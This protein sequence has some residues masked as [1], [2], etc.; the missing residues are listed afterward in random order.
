MTLRTARRAGSAVSH[1]SSLSP[2]G[3]GHK[4]GG[5]TPNSPRG[6]PSAPPPTFAVQAVV[7]GEHNAAAHRVPFVAAGTEWVPHAAAV[8]DLPIICRSDSRRPP[9]DTGTPHVLWDP[10]DP[11]SPKLMGW[12]WGALTRMVRHRSPAPAGVPVFGVILGEDKDPSGYMLRWGTR[13]DPPRLPRPPT[14]RASPS[15]M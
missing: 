9:C 1:G 4:M 8:E 10:P 13:W 11:K 14:L 15:A 2:G 12:Q 6:S 3:G 5:V 7:A